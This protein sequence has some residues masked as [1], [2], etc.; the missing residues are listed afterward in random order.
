MIF[1]WDR[2][3]SIGAE[4]GLSLAGFGVLVVLVARLMTAGERAQAIGVLTRLRESLPLM[5]GGL[6]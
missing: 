4:L 1:L 6:P 3:I 5:R 2:T